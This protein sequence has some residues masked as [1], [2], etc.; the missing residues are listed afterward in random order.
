MLLTKQQTQKS[1]EQ[2]SIQKY[3]HIYVFNWFSINMQRQFN[4]GQLLLEQL[5]IDRPKDEL[6]SYHTPHTKIN[7]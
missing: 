6:Q 7:S 5:N 2:T 1:K 3:T 4:G